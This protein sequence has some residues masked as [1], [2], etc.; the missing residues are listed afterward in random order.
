MSVKTNASS[1]WIAD[2][3]PDLSGRTIIVTGASSGIG[4]VSARELARHGA[5]VILAVRDVQK[6]ANVASSFAGVT[7]V[8]ALDLSDLESV[9]AF[10]AAWNG[11]L[12]TLINNAG[13]MMV[14]AARTIDDFEMHFGTNH[15]GPFALTNLLLPFITNRVVTVSSILHRQGL[16]HFEDLNFEHRPYD[17]MKA[18][19][20]TKLAN[21][22]FAY[23][24]QRRLEAAKS[25]VRSMAAHPGIAKT[26]LMSHVHGARGF[27]TSLTQRL[28][29]DDVRGALPTLFAA[30]QD[31]PGGS[32]V[33]PNGIAHLRGYPALQR[34]SKRSRD[35][36]LA[37]QLWATSAQLTGTGL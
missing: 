30:T 7:E 21:L 31:I 26:N 36:E 24:L 8:R 33:G 16:I 22:L 12:D 17:A 27:A 23:E 19:Q 37:R 4:L 15:L 1:K 34:S 5:R 10:A 13:I 20:D 9:R 32:Y 35:V 18:Y 3:M 2:D 25:S 29:N 6:G 28:L 11:P 14:P